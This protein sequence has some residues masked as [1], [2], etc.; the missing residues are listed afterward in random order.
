[1]N[2]MLH[3]CLL[4]ALAVA[5][6]CKRETTDSN[7]SASPKPPST[8]ARSESAAPTPQ[9]KVSLEDLLAATD[10]NSPAPNAPLSEGDKAWME[11]LKA[12]EL[13][14][15]PAEW[16]ATAPTPEAVS[17]FKSTNAMIVA[18]V[19]DRAHQFYT[20][21]PDHTKANEARER[22]RFLLGVAEQ[23]GNTNVAARL[24][25]LDEVRLKDPKLPEDERF[26]LRFQ[27]VV[28]VLSQNPETITSAVL[29]KMEGSIRALQKE[30]TNQTELAALLLTPAEGRL[31]NNEPDKARA[32]ATEVADGTSEGEVQRAAQALLKKINRVG[33][34]LEVKFKSVDGREVDLQ[35]MK[36]KVVLIDFWATWC[37]PC[38]AELPKVKATHDKLH[39]KGF[40]I[41][42]ISFDRDKA[43]LERVLKREKME[44]PQ[45][46]DE[47]AEG[48]AFGEQFEIESIP[49]MWL[50]DKKGNLRNV[51][52]RDKLAEKVEKLL[53]E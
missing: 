11:L 33:K 14:S 51:S 31:N 32:L 6:G 52:A 29:D 40:E 36:G 30:F 28:R 21:Y 18:V 43:T 35:S 53:A 20:K 8:S 10:T 42:G 39:S 49:A 7:A 13:P 25:A 50:V 12:M 46:F 26:E 37:G 16:E 47:S 38:M 44:W 22:E 45:H 23:L 15:P 1:M 9:V 48:N 2:K 24:E 17:A 5:P 27:Q 3:L 4:L 34:P 41:I 19:A